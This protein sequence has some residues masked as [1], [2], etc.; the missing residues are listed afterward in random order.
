MERPEPTV[1]QFKV[2]KSSSGPHGGSGSGPHGAQ[3]S[4][5]HGG[6]GPPDLM[7]QEARGLVE[8]AQTNRLRSS[9]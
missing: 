6:S 4:G 2:E 3:A 1:A 9:D 8:S 7:D 5:P